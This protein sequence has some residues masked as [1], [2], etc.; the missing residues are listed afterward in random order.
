MS[1]H[2]PDC[3]VVTTRYLAGPSADCDCNLSHEDGCGCIDCLDDIPPLEAAGRITLGCDTTPKDSERASYLEHRLE[4]QGVSERAQLLDDDPAWVA[5]QAATAR[6][7][8]RCV[9]LCRQYA[10]TADSTT[11]EIMLGH[12]ADR[13]ECDDGIEEVRGE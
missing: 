6:E 1:E 2:R 13:L 4:E 8:A 11:V 3:A 7:R 10:L 5:Y 12:V 9:D